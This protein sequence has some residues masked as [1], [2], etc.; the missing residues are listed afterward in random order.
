AAQCTRTPYGGPC[1]QGSQ[2]NNAD[3]SCEEDPRKCVPPNDAEQSQG[4]SQGGA[5]GS[6]G[7]GTSS[8]SNQE[9]INHIDQAHLRRKMAILQELKC[10]WIMLR[11]H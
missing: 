4:G 8:N 10:I 1:N 6:S 3:V 5:S 11:I 2:Q 9:A 7:S